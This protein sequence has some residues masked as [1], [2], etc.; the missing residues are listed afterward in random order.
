MGTETLRNPI[1][2]DKPLPDITRSDIK[3]VLETLRGKAAS[4]RKLYAILR[5]LFHWAVSEESLERSPLEDVEAPP[6]PPSRDH[7]LADWELRLAFEAAGRLRRP[8]GPFIRLLVLTG[9]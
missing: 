9:Q 5:R 8:F 4:R 2:R 1:L 6:N 7:V 3:A